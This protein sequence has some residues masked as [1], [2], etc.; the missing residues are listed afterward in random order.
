MLQIIIARC[1]YSLS[2]FNKNKLMHQ[3]LY[4]LAKKAKFIILEINILIAMEN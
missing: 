2:P 3:R 4:L 1:G